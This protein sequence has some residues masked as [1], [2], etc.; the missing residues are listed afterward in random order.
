MSL[1]GAKRR[2]NLTLRRLLRSLKFARNNK[3]TKWQNPR[4]KLG[5]KS[6]LFAQFAKPS[7]IFPKKTDLKQ[8]TN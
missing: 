8:R 6:D 3:Y 1:R 4:K 7:T 2:G 5:L